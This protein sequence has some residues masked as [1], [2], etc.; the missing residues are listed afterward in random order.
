MFTDSGGAGV[1]AALGKRFC[2]CP[3]SRNQISSCYS[4]GYNDGISA[5]CKQYAKLGV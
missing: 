4:Y 5:D 1:F 3:H 2:C